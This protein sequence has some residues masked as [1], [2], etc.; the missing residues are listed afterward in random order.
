M[1]LQACMTR[2]YTSETFC[3]EGSQPDLDNLTFR[4]G[5]N[6]GIQAGPVTPC[7]ISMDCTQVSCMHTAICST[8]AVVLCHLVIMTVLPRKCR[9]LKEVSCSASAA[10]LASAIN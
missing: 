9:H 7:Y 5:C 4:V 6:I 1:P 3:L 8:A 10:H 2:R